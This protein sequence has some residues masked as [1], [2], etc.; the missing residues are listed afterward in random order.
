LCFNAIAFTSTSKSTCRS[1]LDARNSVV[2]LRR[3]LGC[4]GDVARAEEAAR[5]L[6]AAAHAQATA[7]GSEVRAQVGFSPVA[8][9][10][11]EPL[12]STFFGGK[13][14]DVDVDIQYIAISACEP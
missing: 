7:D 5:L 6:P 11:I 14:K 8:A 9:L 10:M 1:A 13:N 4:L 12:R 3:V 2:K